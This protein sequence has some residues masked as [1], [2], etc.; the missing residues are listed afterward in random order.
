MISPE[1]KG[2]INLSY[3]SCNRKETTIPGRNSGVLAGTQCTHRNAIITLK[4]NDKE[5]FE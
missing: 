4:S 1:G 3:N 5:V 2:Q